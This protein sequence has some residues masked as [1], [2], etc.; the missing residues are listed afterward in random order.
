MFTA[1]SFLFSVLALF[2]VGCGGA[3]KA[4]VGWYGPTD[5]IDVVVQKMN[6]NNHAIPTLYARH[7]LEAN[8][9]DRER[10]KTNFVNAS[11][12]LF[13]FKPRDLLL[14]GKK[15]AVG[16]IFELGSTR[17]QYW[18]SVFV[19]EPTQWWGNYRNVG[20]KCSRDIPI[21]PDLIGEVLGVGD[22]SANLVEPPVPTM[23]FNNDLDVYMFVWS[24][25]L[26][27]RWYAEKEVWY[28]RATY[29]PRKVLLFDR[30][31]RIV[32]RA[33]LSGHKQVQ[34]AGLPQAQWPWIATSYD[35]FFPETLSTMTLTL[36]DMALTTK[37][38]NPKPGTIVFKEASRDD[39][40]VIQIDEDCEK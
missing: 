13:L 18:F 1:K 32:L 37:N 29:R 6:A 7:Y 14:R 31:G 24:G 36:S 15:D 21:R 23:R 39:M 10:K 28:D 27:D 30:N 12:D 3:P 22:I 34:V 40:K 33:D 8:I 25:R 5:S 17:D 16:N 11:G 26:A 19:E 9:V 20:K 4:P 2:F 35:L 38:G